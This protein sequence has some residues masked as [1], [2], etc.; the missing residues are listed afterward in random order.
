MLQMEDSSWCRDPEALRHHIYDYYSNVYKTAG[1]RN[2]QPVL[3]QCKS[4]IDDQINASLEANPTMEEIKTAVFQLGAMKAP[5]PDGFN[6][7][8]Y[9]N[10]WEIMQNDLFQLVQDFFNTGVLDPHLNRTYIALIPK[11][12]NPEQ[13]AFVKGRQIQDNILIV[14][15]VLHQLVFQSVQRPKARRSSV[16]IL[17][18]PYVCR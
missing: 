3:N 14:Q 17:V 4:P 5:G 11:V 9:Q 15:E 12:K 13:S 18:Y 16:A 2:Y 7:L 6:G 8:F 10:S 1:E